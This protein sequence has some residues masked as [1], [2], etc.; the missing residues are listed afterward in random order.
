LKPS[1]DNVLVIDL[2]KETVYNWFKS[3]TD[4]LWLLVKDENE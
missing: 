1:L 3:S 2:D 4:S